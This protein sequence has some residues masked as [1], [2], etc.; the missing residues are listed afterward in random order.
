MIGDLCGLADQLPVERLSKRIFGALKRCSNEAIE[1]ALWVVMWYTHMP[2]GYHLSP[3]PGI[4]K[5]P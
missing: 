5:I 2:L 3:W 4:I 1:P